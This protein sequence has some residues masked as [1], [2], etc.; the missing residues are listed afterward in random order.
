M[1]SNLSN[2][3]SKTTNSSKPRNNTK[4]VKKQYWKS[5]LG[6]KRKT[7]H[8]SSYAVNSKIPESFT[9]PKSHEPGLKSL[10]NTRL[11][12]W[13]PNQRKN[14]KHPKS[15]CLQPQKFYVGL[16]S[17]FNKVLQLSFLFMAHLPS[18]G[19]RRTCIDVTEFHRLQCCVHMYIVTD[20]PRMHLRRHGIMFSCSSISTNIIYVYDHTIITTT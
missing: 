16:F 8:P 9:E 19:L 17:E 14:Q 10:S 13:F 18:F 11:S 5:S 12:I 3:C 7:N 1:S 15:F 2:Q 20:G 4:F 6:E